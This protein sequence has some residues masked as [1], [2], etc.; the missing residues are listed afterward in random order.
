MRKLIA[1]T[2]LSA[3]SASALAKPADEPNRLFQGRDLF[4]LQLRERSADP[5]RRARGRV[6]ARLVR[7]HDGSRPPV[8]LADRLGKRR[9]DAARHRPPARIRSRAGRRTAIASR[10]FRRPKAAGRSCSCAGCR[11]SQT[12]KLAD[13]TDCA[14][15]TSSWSPDGKWIAFT[16]FAPDEK[17]QLGEAPP[18]PEGAEWAPPLEVIT[19]IDLSHRR[20]RLSQARLHTY[21]CR[22]R[23]RRRA[24]AAD[25]RRV[26]RKRSD[27]V[28]AGRQVA[29]R[30]RQS[31]AR[32]GSA[33]RSTPRSI[34]VTL[35]DGAIQAADH[36][37]RPGQRRR[38]LARRQVDRVS[39]L[40]RQVPR[41]PERRALRDG[42][43][44]AATRAR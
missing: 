43:A 34:S 19:D 40:R 30:H 22:V 42:R 10:T 9:A 25:V 27:L 37:Q 16:M 38:R 28:G 24:A 23:R 12:A 36:A 32:T 29:A 1:L 3:V 31:R 17:A 4:A 11:R 13:L 35:A 33:S 2:L 14:A 21:I 5:A 7:H 41:L 20:R 44:T 8:D 15:A 18:K 26:Q 39:R 6:R